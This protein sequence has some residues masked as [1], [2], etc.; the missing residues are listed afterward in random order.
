MRSTDRNGPIPEVPATPVGVLG[1]TLALLESFKNADAS[2]TLAELSRRTGLPKATVHRMTA[3]MRRE[4]M[5][6]QL[7]DGSYRLGLRLFEIGERVHSHRSL[8]QA[9]LPIME[10]LREATRQRI[11]LAVLE[12]VDVVYVEILGAN[13][14]RQI[15]SRTGG[16]FPAHATGV[17]KAILAYSPVAVVRA[18]IDAGLDRVT[19]R[20][21]TTPGALQRELQEIRTKG[22]AQDREESHVG[23]SCVAAAAF[24]SDSKVRAALSI[25]GRT[26]SIDPARLGPAIRIA[27]NTLSRALRES[28]L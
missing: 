6:E 7:D 18:R 28:H 11:H 17:G 15:G 23:V 24:G 5:L 12:G 22:F 20:T 25:T 14:L 9:A 27:A 21:I 8:S 26:T 2:L 1:R 16:R 4:H 13:L 10:D 19:P 3:E